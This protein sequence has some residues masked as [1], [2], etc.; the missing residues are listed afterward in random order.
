MIKKIILFIII[1][2]IPF[3]I[4]ASTELPVDVLN[5]SIEEI[6]EAHSLGLFTYEELVS[7]YLERIDKYNEQYN[8]II[9]INDD[10][11]KQAK[12]LDEEYKK[13]GLTSKLM[14]IPIIV[15]DNIDVYG[16]P[17]TAGTF[18]LK[19]NYPNKNSLVAQRLIDSGAIIIA[20]SNM[21]EF[22]F[23][24]NNSKSSYGH[25]YNA[26]NI[27]YSPYGSSG[28]TAVAVA[29]G[30]AV[31][32][33]GTDTN[34][35]IRTPSS[36]NNIIGLRPTFGLVDDPGVIKYDS[37]RDTIGP[38]TK[39]V[40]DNKLILEV[41]SGKNINKKSDIQ[42]I[43]IGVLSS[44]MLETSNRE[45]TALSSTYKGIVS[46]MNKALKIFK[47]NGIEIVE[48]NDFY[49]YKYENL[50][51][52]TYFGGM[53]LC[54][55]FNKYIKNTKSKIGSYKELI[56]KGGYIQ[57]LEEYNTNC[58]TNYIETSLYDTNKTDREKF[59]KYVDE[60]MKKY[61]VDV[62]IYPT[63][64][65]KLLKISET[66]IVD[67][68]TNSYVIAPTIG[69]PSIN[70]PLG[71]DEESLPYGMEILGKTNSE[72]LLYSLASLY[73]KNTNYYKLPDIAPNLYELPKK[74]DVLINYYKKNT[75]EKYKELNIKVKDFFEKYN[76][77][78]EKESLI[79][80]YI[81]EYQELNK[82]E[83]K[84]KKHKK[85]L[86]VI[87]SII[88][89]ILLIMLHSIYKMININNKKMFNKKKYF[90]KIKRKR[91]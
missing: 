11:I 41:I 32:G 26:Y 49:N 58:Y 73:E 81:L 44:W 68:K 14:G 22:A 71:F 40:S 46:L 90:K 10:A 20:K 1:L 86:I 31:A 9:T 59:K 33:L 87:F 21:S 6:Q 24:A 51:T 8:C 45:T 78:E 88:L 89:L 29:S 38:M 25:T 61:G 15:K 67:L 42:N 77:I 65:N 66:G 48:I 82:E 79:N 47:N 62:L 72:N 2:L 12:E 83:I 28:G 34:A 5:M 91:K 50:V 60:T 19:D 70:V 63:T 57:Y 74:I 55:E 75:N 64:K 7:F 43:K 30:L 36:A 35:S 18:A 4:K 69:Y 37:T 85:F 56:N 16:M 80:K 3:N 23:S 84:D 13:K 39:Y 53:T 52:S 17:T 54:Y 76:Q 27:S